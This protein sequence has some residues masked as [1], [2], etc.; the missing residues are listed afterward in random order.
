MWVAHLRY[1]WLNVGGVVAGSVAELEPPD[2]EPHQNF[3]PEPEPQKNDAAPQHW[4]LIGKDALFVDVY[5][6]RGLLLFNL[7]P[8]TTLL[9]MFRY[10]SW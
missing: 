7:P 8:Y 3:Y 4:W 9:L 6:Y 2:P 5:R 1:G 10:S